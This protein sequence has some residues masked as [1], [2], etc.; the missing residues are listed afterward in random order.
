MT[1]HAPEL[2]VELVTRLIASQ[3]PRW[4][5]LTVT[6]VLPGGNDNRTFRLGEEFLVRLPSAASYAPQVMKEH[7]W[8]PVLAAELPLPIPQP[9]AQGAADD[10]YPWPW[11]VY[12]WLDGTAASDTGK[13]DLADCAASLG[14]FLRALHRIETGGAPPPGEHNFHRGGPLATYDAETRAAIAELGQVLPG[15]AAV[16]VWEAALG[17]PWTGHPVWVHGD[18]AAGN[19]LVDGDGRLAAVIDFG[20]CAVGDPACDLT[21]AWTL[22]DQSGRGMF[23]DRVGLDDGTWTRAR[24]WALWKALITLVECIGTGSDEESAT[25][26]VISEVLKDHQEAAQ[27]AVESS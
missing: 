17:A 24:G 1:H 8:L 9:V 3:F 2:S 6:E 4:A 14:D 22:L 11:S 13:V 27:A 19:L 18:V 12:R 26:R 7:R 10:H 20:C 21:V 25:H 15:D 16:G 5:G 23:R